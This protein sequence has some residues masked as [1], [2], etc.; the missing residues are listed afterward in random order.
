[1]YS[2]WVISLA[3]SSSLL[4]QTGQENPVF[5]PRPLYGVGF[6]QRL[7]ADDMPNHDLLTSHMW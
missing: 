6:G 5:K 3:A 7:N 4:P 1:M 2:F